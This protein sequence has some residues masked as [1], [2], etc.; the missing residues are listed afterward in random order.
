MTVGPCDSLG[1]WLT[2]SSGQEQGEDQGPCI[3]I[4]LP[5]GNLVMNVST[6]H[7]YRYYL[8]N[9]MMM[10]LPDCHGDFRLFKP[11]CSKFAICWYKQEDMQ[12]ITT[13]AFQSS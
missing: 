1:L 7:M 12:R 2:V 13:S 9:D 4:V 5:S 3:C 8:R 6:V 11:F 10:F